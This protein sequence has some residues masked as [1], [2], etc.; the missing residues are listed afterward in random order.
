MSKDT[1]IIKDSHPTGDR[2]TANT[3]A[4]QIVRNMKG[5]VKKTK[6]IIVDHETG[7]V[8]GEGE[9]K[10]LVPGSQTTA[11]K[12]FGIDQVV[13]FPTYNSEL[14][15]ENSY[16]DWTMPPTNDPITC[17]WCVGQSGYLNIPDEIIV[18]DTKDRIAPVD[19]ILPFR[20]VKASED[21]DVDQRQTYFGRKPM[22][23]GEHVAYYFKKF[24]TEPMLHVRYMDGTEV[25]PNMWNIDTPQEVEVFVEMRLSVSRL[26][27]RDYFDQVIGWDKAYIN[28]ISLC[29]AWY[30]NDIP[31]DPDDPES[32]HYRWF[33]DIIPFT[34]FN[35]KN[36]ELTEL[37][38]AVDFIY[39]IYY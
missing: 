5:G 29:T 37:N 1:Y 10:I 20:Y 39:Q 26:D 6:I 8:L 30:R 13:L 4:T 22:E 28:T 2:V 33:Q 12:Q 21:L 36:N 31:E 27:F 25:G 15:L 17:L 24:D 35:F 11:C 14:G 34:K 3:L 19:D 9:N 32:V 7:K 18:V 16:P 23:D 38:K